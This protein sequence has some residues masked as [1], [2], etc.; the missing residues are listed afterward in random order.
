M[1]RNVFFKIPAA[2]PEVEQYKKT[3]K[4]WFWN[5]ELYCEDCRV[6]EVVVIKDME[7]VLR[8]FG[9]LDNPTYYWFAW[10]GPWAEGY[11]SE[12]PFVKETRDY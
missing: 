7:F 12:Y 3:I 1:A 9:E 10:A 8:E 5:E 2:Q 6:E 11:F 4:H